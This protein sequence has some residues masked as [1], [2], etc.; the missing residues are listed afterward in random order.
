MIWT[1]P[2]LDALP[3]IPAAVRARWNVDTTYARTLRVKYG[4]TPEQYLEI[5]AFQ[6]GRCA[7]CKRW[8]RS[9]RLNVDHEHSTGIVR[10]LLCWDCNKTLAWYKDE[11]EAFIRAANYLQNGTAARANMYVTVPEG[12]DETT[13]TKRREA[14]TKWAGVQQT[15][16]AA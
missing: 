14:G 16:E 4:L 8:P 5:L 6:E 7:I 1:H 12:A 13:K 2:S 15:K 9:R 3:K 11:A 10:G